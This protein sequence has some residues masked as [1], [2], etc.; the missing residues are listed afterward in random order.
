MPLL[1]LMLRTNRTFKSKKV[2]LSKDTFNFEGGT[3]YINSD[4]IYLMKRWFRYKPV[5]VFKEGISQPIGFTDIIKKQVKKDVIKKVKNKDGSITEITE[6]KLV[7]DDTVLID[8]R[9]IHRLTSDA[10]LGFITKSKTQALITIAIIVG[11]INIFINIG[12]I[13]A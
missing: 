10:I 5:L 4:R 11:I 12:G 3:Y 8:A 2:A 7:D 1:C 13:V 9:S 6:N